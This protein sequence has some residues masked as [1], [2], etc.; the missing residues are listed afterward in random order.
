M[1][2]DARFQAPYYVEDMRAAFEQSLGRQSRI[3]KADLQRNP[4]LGRVELTGRQ[5]KV[6]THDADD[7]VLL[8][9]EQDVLADDRL[10][11][12]ES[13]LPQAVRDDC[14]QRRPRGFVLSRD[15]TSE[16]WLHAE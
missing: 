15:G 4:D 1:Q 10:V 6:L 16:N 5:A 7:R 11:A 3:S 12:G 2:G 8:A 14:C 13:A 9:A